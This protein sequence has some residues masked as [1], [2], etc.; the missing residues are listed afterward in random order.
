MKM[1]GNEEIIWRGIGWDKGF[2]R[3]K[4]VWGVRQERVKR[5]TVWEVPELLVKTWDFHGRLWS[6]STHYWLSSHK[7]QTGR[8]AS[9]E[10]SRCLCCPQVESNNFTLCFFFSFLNECDVGLVA[11]GTDFWSWRCWVMG[12]VDWDCKK[13]MVGFSLL[14][15]RVILNPTSLHI[16]TRI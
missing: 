1:I 5:A 10:R 11:C 14:E 9:G 4:W 2:R 8:A 6:R 7:T 12:C 15:I 3:N 16:K 13:Y